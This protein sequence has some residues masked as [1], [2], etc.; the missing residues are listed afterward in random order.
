MDRNFPLYVTCPHCG[1]GAAELLPTI[2]DR[3]D[4]RCSKCGAFSTAEYRKRGL[5]RVLRILPRRG[6][7]RAARVVGF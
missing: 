2:G 5:K 3:S 1:S 6:S 7:F 4:Y